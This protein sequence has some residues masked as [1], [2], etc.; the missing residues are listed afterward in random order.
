MHWNG[1]LAK[2]TLQ[3][4]LRACAPRMR[5][6]VVRFLLKQI[7]GGNFQNIGKCGEHID[8]R[9]INAS[10]KRAYIGP[11]NTSLMRK[12]LLRQSLCVS[13]HSEVARK[14]FTNFHI[15]TH[16]RRGAFI[17]GVNSTN[18]RLRYDLW[19]LR[20]IVTA[21]HPTCSEVAKQR[22]R[23]CAKRTA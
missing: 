12:L 19:L 16:A 3:P 22:I 13:H 4:L 15:R 17:Y 6:A 21:K 8:G 5:I 10:L 20:T 7:S 2:Q 9:T 1:M 14:N 23:G 18:R 11:I